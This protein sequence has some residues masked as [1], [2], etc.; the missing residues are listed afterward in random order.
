[1]DI[2]ATP[3]CTIPKQKKTETNGEA[4]TRVYKAPVNEMRKKNQNKRRRTEQKLKRLT[5][6]VEHCSCEEGRNGLVQVDAVDEDV[7]LEQRRERTASLCF[8]L[9]GGRRVRHTH[10]KYKVRCERT[11]RQ[12]VQVVHRISTPVT[13]RFEEFFS[14][15][16]FLLSFLFPLRIVSFEG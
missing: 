1:M 7:V 4:K 12:P 5:C 16:F 11:V 2:G 9:V 3:L 14:L 8:S 6:R 15:F 13:V 10:I